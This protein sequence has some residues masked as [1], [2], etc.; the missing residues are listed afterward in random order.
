[1]PSL[2]L[3]PLTLGSLSIAAA[4]ASPIVVYAQQVNFPTHVSGR[5]PT[6][7]DYKENTFSGTVDPTLYIGY[8]QD[9]N[10][11]SLLAGEPGLSWCVEGNYNDG[12]GQ[13]KMEAY[14][15]FLKAAGGSSIRPIFAQLN[16][17]T[18][19]V[20]ALSFN[21]PDTTFYDGASEV[22]D[23]AKNAV[24]IWAPNAVDNTLRLKADATHQSKLA[25]GSNGT[26]DRLVVQ[27]AA[28]T[29]GEIMVGGTMALRIYSINSGAAGAL[30]VGGVNDNSATLI[31][32]NVNSY[33]NQPAFIA[34]AKSGQTVDIVQVQ[35][36]TPA[37]LGGWD[38]N[39]YWFTK[40]N[41]A[42]ADGDLAAGQMMIWFDSTAG[43]S[44]LMV[45][46]K[47]ASGTVVTGSLALA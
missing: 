11:N 8:N 34:R 33:V 22:M 30:A 23:V 46:A 1:M 47:N 18:E 10:G 24:T 4:A 2:V 20:S 25:L 35:S 7:V 16:R 45:K 38:K 28:T 37:V 13:N 36:S 6:V 40:N 31:A 5:G 21:S 43:A 29:R 39:G 27:T 19:T 17:S 3:T 42:P 15:Q 44:K 32:D 14:L 26:D 12:T 41:A 9:A